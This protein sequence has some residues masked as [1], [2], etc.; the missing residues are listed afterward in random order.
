MNCL[1]LHYLEE[2]YSNTVLFY[3]G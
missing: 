3:C 2:Q 1:M